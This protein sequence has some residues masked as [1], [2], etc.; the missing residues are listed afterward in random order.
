MEEGKPFDY[1]MA[2]TEKDLVSAE[3][4]IYWVAKGEADPLEVLKKHEGRIPILH[5]KDMA[6]GFQKRILTVREA[7]SLISPQ[8]L[9][10]PT[11]RVLSTILWNATIVSMAWHAWNRAERI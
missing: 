6:A 8:S 5:V 10:R 7:V 11:A 3:M 2:H 1:L 4:D 9:Q